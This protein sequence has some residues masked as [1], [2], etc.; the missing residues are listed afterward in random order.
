ML[1]VK[2]SSA[3]QAGPPFRACCRFCLHGSNVVSHHAPCLPTLP[4]LTGCMAALE[5]ERFLEDHGEA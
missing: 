3:Q 5:V 4:A 2:A 1:D